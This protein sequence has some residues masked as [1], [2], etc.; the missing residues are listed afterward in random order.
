ML[1]G[2][3]VISQHLEKDIIIVKDKTSF[4]LEMWSVSKVY[5]E[6][7]YGYISS[8]AMQNTANTGNI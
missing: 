2:G 1:N 6:H 3:W 8:T 7:K 4:A 5:P